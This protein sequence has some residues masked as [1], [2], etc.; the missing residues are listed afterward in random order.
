VL[1]VERQEMNTPSPAAAPLILLVD[2]DEATRMIAREV[3]Q[4]SGFRVLEAADGSAGLD[5]FRSNTVDLVV[6]DVMMPVLDGFETCIAIRREKVGEHT[7]V[8]MMT[9]LDDADSI[10][11][12]FEAGATDFITKPVNHTMLTYR[13]RYM[14]RTAYTSK[15]LRE[16]QARLENAEKMAKLGHWEWYLETG[17][18]LC[19]SRIEKLFGVTSRSV[20]NGRKVFRDKVHPEDRHLLDEAFTQ[21]L[22]NGVKSQCNYRI[23]TDHLGLRHV[24]QEAMLIRTAD[25][26]ESCFTG[27]IQDVTA[28]KRAEEQAHQLAYFDNVTGLPN[29][30]LL[31]QELARSLEL[32]IRHDRQAC[33]LALDIDDFKRIN[34]TLG[35]AVGNKILQDVALRLVKCVMASDVSSIDEYNESP[36]ESTVARISGDEFVIVLTEIQS[37]EEAALV[38]RRIREKLAEPMNLSGEEIVLTCSTGISVFPT[39]SNTADDLLANA[40][41]AMNSAKAKG[42]V[43]G[44]IRIWE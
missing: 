11:Q 20:I 36:G 30:R 40:G 41:T 4:Q 5:L 38:S 9:G 22:E 44:A 8:L 35:Y 2:D 18:F 33:V 13:V 28:R 27:T 3:L 16:S 6:L 26:A 15:E 24:H 31:K 17:L 23:I 19:S 25:N 12:A 39:D 21:V 10:H 1:A 32:A 29:R 43:G 34:D 14:M 42:R 7:P 37:A